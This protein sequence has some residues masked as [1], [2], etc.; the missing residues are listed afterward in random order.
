MTILAD[1]PND[2]FRHME[3]QMC[4]ENVLAMRD[5]FKY[6]GETFV[7]PNDEFVVACEK[8]QLNY[9][10]WLYEIYQIDIWYKQLCALHLAVINEHFDVV[11]WLCE[12]FRITW[13]DLASFLPR[14]EEEEY[15]F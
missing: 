8:N 2:V 10:K 6:K 14:E 12:E 5:L 4:D 1:M 3:T 7:N 13:D 9:A 11:D 15:S